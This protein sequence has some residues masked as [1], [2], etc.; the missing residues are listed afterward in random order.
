MAL[1]TAAQDGNWSAAG[2]WDTGV[3]VDGDTFSIPAGRIVTFNVDQTSMANGMGASVID[4]TLKFT[5]AASTTT[6][7]KMN[8]AL[9]GAG[10]LYIGNSDADPI[11]ATSTATIQMNGTYQI[12]MLVKAYGAYRTAFKT[13]V[14]SIAASGQKDIVLTDDLALVAGDIIAV[15]R[16]DV[17][18]VHFESSSLG[19]GAY[20]VQ[21]YNAGTKTVTVTVN[22]QYQ[23]TAGSYVGI[24]SQPARI[25]RPAVNTTPFFTL[26]NDGRLQGVYCFGAPVIHNCVDWRLNYCGFFQCTQIAQN[27]RN[28]IISNCVSLYNAGAGISLVGANY[29]ISDC[30][31]INSANAATSMGY[32]HKVTNCITQNVKRGLNNG[33]IGAVYIDCMALSS[34]EGPLGYIAYDCTYIN[35]TANKV[36]N[37]GVY[38]GCGGDY[39][40]CTFIDCGNSAVNSMVKAKLVNCTISGT[41]ADLYVGHLLAGVDFP[42]HQTIESFDH[43]G[44]AG[45][46]KGYCRGG[47]MTKQSTTQYDGRD[48][49]QFT[50]QTN[51]Y[52]YHIHRDWNVY[53][54][55]GT[56]VQCQGGA[57]KNYSGGTVKVQII[58]PA[59]DPLIV[60]GAV[61]LAEMSLPDVADTWAH[62]CANYTPTTDKWLILRVIAIPATGT[63]DYTYFDPYWNDRF[64]GNGSP[65]PL[66]TRHW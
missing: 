7:L 30:I 10:T 31:V 66:L 42:N 34:S 21:S 59:N 38:Y 14:A 40:D 35:C 6:L 9:S 17:L 44:V 52:G 19:Y 46:F 57:R 36:T 15:G 11:P 24:L 18:D 61:A 3:P 55:A 65:I 47:I 64:L 25:V 2:T 54:K 8:G 60:S 43:L 48:T 26:V 33:C 29:Q 58:D 53:A 4:G 28:H 56:L 49:L 32:G 45:A 12:T 13:T 41:T 23:R 20:I 37:A 50:H 62:L 5:T 1:R 63:G 16:S 39:R 22:L 27:Y 51:T